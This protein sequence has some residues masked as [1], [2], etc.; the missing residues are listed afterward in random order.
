VRSARPSLKH[1]LIREDLAELD[2]PMLDVG[3][4]HALAF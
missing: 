2:A 1:Y 4:R 3:E